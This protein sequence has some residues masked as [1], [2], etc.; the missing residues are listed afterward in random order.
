MKAHL[1]IYKAVM[2]ARSSLERTTRERSR[3]GE[4]GVWALR[5][6]GFDDRAILFR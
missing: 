6:A 5:D 1:E 4:A 2:F 3:S